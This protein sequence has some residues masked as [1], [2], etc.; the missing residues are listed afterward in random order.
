[1]TRLGRP[2]GPTPDRKRIPGDPEYLTPE[3]HHALRVVA[4]NELR[5]S[6]RRRYELVQ[7]VR[8]GYATLSQLTTS[9]LGQATLER[10]MALPAEEHERFLLENLK[11]VAKR[12]R[13][14]YRSQY[15][16]TDT[17]AGQTDDQP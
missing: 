3:D 2:T 12:R 7:Y 10:Y 5:A 15:T 6:P 9:A 17:N 8:H 11:P 16:T 14:S 1:V 13:R 4:A